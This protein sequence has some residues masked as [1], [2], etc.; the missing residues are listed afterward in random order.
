[1]GYLKK[2][3]QSAGFVELYNSTTRERMVEPIAIIGGAL[4]GL[5]AA[6]AAVIPAFVKGDMSSFEV[7][8]AFIL[9]LTV[10]YIIRDRLKEHSKIYLTKKL[11]SV[12]P[13]RKSEL[14]YRG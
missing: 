13:N 14:R 12:I 11:S 10:A 9:S 5:V 8:L 1:F 7:L 2:Y 3:F 6:L 4:A